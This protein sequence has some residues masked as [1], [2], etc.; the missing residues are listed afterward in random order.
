MSTHTLESASKKSH[1]TRRYAFQH[2]RLGTSNVDSMP[3]RHK[4]IALQHADVTAAMCL[5]NS[6]DDDS[7]PACRCVTISQAVE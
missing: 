3:F 4:M 2:P 6:R 7:I 1:R 5:S